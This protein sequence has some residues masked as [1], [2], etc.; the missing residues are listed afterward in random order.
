M[1]TQDTSPD[2]VKMFL[3][4][5]LVLECITMNVHI[6][7]KVHF[8]NSKS[9]YINTKSTVL[10]ILFYKKRSLAPDTRFKN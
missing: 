7:K 10:L 1:S 2:V 5:Y 8:M 6:L 3:L 4:D 9:V